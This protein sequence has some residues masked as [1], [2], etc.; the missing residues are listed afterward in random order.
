VTDAQRGVPPAPGSIGR[1]AVGSPA[2][3]AIALWIAAVWLAFSGHRDLIHPDEG[4]YAEI[5]REMVASG[6][7]ITPR[8]DGLKYFE[9][10]PLQYWATA[11]AFQFFGEGNA[12]ARVWPIGLGLLSVLWVFLL[13]RRLFGAET[14]AIGAVILA[15][16]LL[17][18]ALGHILTLDTGLSAFLALALGAM[19]WAQTHRGDPAR[20]VR[21]MLVAWAALGA[22]VLSKGP[23]AILLTGGTLVLYSFWQRD[24]AIWKHLHLGKGLLVLTA[25]AAPWFVVVGLRHPEFTS[26]F[27]LHENFARYTTDVHGRVHP[28]WTFVPVVLVGSMPWIRPAVLALVRP[29]TAWRSG[30]GGFDPVRLL[31]VWCVFTVVFFSASHS[32]LPPYVQPVFP[33]LALLAARQLCQRPGLVFEAAT[34]IVFG[35][36]V[37]AIPLVPQWIASPDLPRSLLVGYRP[38]ILWAAGILVVAGVVVLAS[39]WRGLRGVACLG[40]GAALAFKVL[41]LGFQTLSPV[42]SAHELARAIDAEVGREAPVYSVSRYDQPLPFYL[43]RTVVL[44]NFRGE[45]EFGLEQ[46]P[47]RGIRDLESFRERW[48][49]EEQAAAVFGTDDYRS[50]LA[51]GLPMRVIYEDPRRVAVARR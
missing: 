36:V 50:M 45:L 6:D 30:A 40:G 11:A 41:L 48:R 2:L 8:L 19:A 14:G 12:T 49:S 43:R 24:F 10:P 27:F 9:K 34:A 4:R 17:W 18:V 46:E 47:Q 35:L 22:A 20:V 5:P 1:S 25:V 15:S 37:A 44:V 13:G 51:T 31:W 39:R 3:L 26:F 16:S 32:K 38:Y 7:W 42:Q 33:A 28:W 21:W 29:G 23:V